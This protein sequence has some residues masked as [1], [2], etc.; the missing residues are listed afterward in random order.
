MTV[1]PI[2]AKVSRLGNN[3]FPEQ[4]NKTFIINV[5]L[6]FNMVWKVVSLFLD[7][8]TR[9]KIEFLGSR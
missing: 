3:F 9:V 1:C 7:E 5:P 8:G 4:L 2:A 6:V